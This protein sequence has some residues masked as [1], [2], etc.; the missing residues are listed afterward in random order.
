MP[1]RRSDHNHNG[2]EPIIPQ[3]QQPT[4]ALVVGAALMASA[5]WFMLAGGLSGRLVP[6]TETRTGGT[7]F[8]IDLNTASRT[9]LLQLPGIGPGTA[10][11]ILEW[12]AAHGGLRSPEELLQVLGIGPTTLDRIRPY[13][14]IPEGP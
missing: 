13:L 1:V 2:L 10:D 4:I 14:R 9:E 3:R 11:T 12:R 5:G 6:Y 8:Q 7:G